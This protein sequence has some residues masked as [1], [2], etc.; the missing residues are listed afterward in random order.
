MFY[1][2]NYI[3]LIEEFEIEKNKVYSG[4]E[5][6]GKWFWYNPEMEDDPYYSIMHKLTITV[7]TRI[8][9]C[10]VEDPIQID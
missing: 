2:Q 5:F 6:E 4:C 10:E 8:L 1:K 7:S 3:E 9:I